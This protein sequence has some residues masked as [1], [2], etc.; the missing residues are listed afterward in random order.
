MSKS[1]DHKQVNLANRHSKFVFQHLPY[2]YSGRL[3]PNVGRSYCEITSGK[4]YFV[5]DKDCESHYIVELMCFV[6]VCKKGILGDE[7]LLFLDE[8]Q[9]YWLVEPE[10]RIE[11]DGRLVFELSGCCIGKDLKKKFVERKEKSFTIE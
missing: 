8:K 3:M 2:K 11:S 7:A 9:D 4:K 6:R 5:A 1:E 10:V